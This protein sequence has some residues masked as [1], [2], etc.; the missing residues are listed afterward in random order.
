MD[1]YKLVTGFVALGLAACAAYFSVI[2]IASLMGGNFWQVAIMAGF[3]EAGKLVCASA[4]YR[5]R[6]VASRWI[7]GLLITFTVIMMFITSTGIFGFLSSSYQ[8]AATERDISQQ[9]IENVR[10]KQQTFEQRAE[11]LKEDRKRLIE[12]RNRLQDLRS[13]QGW[14]SE[15]GAERL[16]NIPRQLQQKDSLLS[17]TQDSVLSYNQRITRLQSESNADAKLGPIIFVANTVGLDEDRAALYFILLLIFVF[18][19]MAVTL[20]VALSMATGIEETIEEEDLG[21]DSDE[22]EGSVE[23]YE[24]PT[25]PVVTERDS[26]DPD[27]RIQRMKDYA[28]VGSPADL[29]DSDEDQKQDEEELQDRNKSQ[30]EELDEPQ[31]KD[32]GWEEWFDQ[33]SNQQNTGPDPDRQWL[34]APFGNTNQQ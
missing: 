23:E 2:G 26:L 29:Y 18:D 10:S 17:V 21:E 30:S 34:K 4:A 6:K 22:L 25:E 33:A 1:F 24:D 27:R 8:E 31:E 11:R 16:S 19:P 32:E 14:L 5:F 7:R 3:L 28:S 15:R 9:E 20:V 12:E 13:E